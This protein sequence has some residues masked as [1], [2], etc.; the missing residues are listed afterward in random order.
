MNPVSAVAAVGFVEAGL[1]WAAWR[2]GRRSAPD[3]QAR[4]DYARRIKGDPPPTVD[5]LLAMV[6]QQGEA[7]RYLQQRARVASSRTPTVVLPQLT[8]LAVDEAV[9]RPYIPA[10]GVP[11][12]EDPT[13]LEHDPWKDETR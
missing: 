1:L 11:A 8:P 9:T 7:I 3:W 2:L 12:T 10:Y 5:E 13:V 4:T 6:K